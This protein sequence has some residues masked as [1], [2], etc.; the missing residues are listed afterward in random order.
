MSVTLKEKG[1]WD[2]LKVFLKVSAAFVLSRFYRNAKGPKIALVGGN[3]GEKYGKIPP[4]WVPAPPAAHIIFGNK[5]GL[6]P[7]G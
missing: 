1:R 3:L 2:P 7:A 5:R 6:T 4:L